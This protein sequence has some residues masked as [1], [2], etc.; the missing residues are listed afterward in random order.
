MTKL[1]AVVAAIEIL[2]GASILDTSITVVDKDGFV[3]A[4][5][6]GDFL[7]GLASIKV[8]D[9][10]AVPGTPLKDCLGTGKPR[11]DILPKAMYG[12]KMKART[13]PIIGDDGKLLGAIATSSSMDIPDSLH[14]SA[15]AIAV[16]AEEMSAT[17]QE[18]GITAANLASELAKVKTGGENVLA[19]INK[20]DDILKFVSD[21]ATNSNL[22]G[23][24]A[25]IE[26]ARAGELGRGFAVVADE[27]RKMAVNSAQSVQEIKK[28]LQEIHRETT[29]VV[30]TISK[31][32]EIS[33]R[34]AAATEHI[35]SSMEA[36]A[37]TVTEVE[38]VA[39]KLSN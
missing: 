5:L 33:E 31:T 17:T 18:L 9:M 27:I 29:V 26:A 1:D 14:T 23:L 20:T 10:I 13:L 22:L 19:K 37:S 16:A 4:A 39:G 30:N 34:Q 6:P 21:V 35:A 7:Q 12:I 15:H 8:G 28:I 3:L 36:L 25:A 11:T 38:T 24:N 2:Q 32:S